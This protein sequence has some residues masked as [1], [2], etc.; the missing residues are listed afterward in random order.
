MTSFLDNIRKKPT[1][2]RQKIALTISA[3]LAIIIFSG[4]FV[5]TWNNFNKVSKEE[6]ES[7]FTSPLASI[8]K[9]VNNFTESSYSQFLE[10]KKKFNIETDFFT[11]TVDF[12]NEQYNDIKLM[13][14]TQQ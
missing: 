9:S 5:I 14:E 6:K 13:E 4:W 1:K 8:T 3:F 2:E 11:E 7:N 10:L 12:Q